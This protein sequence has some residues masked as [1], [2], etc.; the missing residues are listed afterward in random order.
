MQNR[1]LEY[2]NDSPTLFIKFKGNS[3]KVEYITNN[4]TTLLG[5]TLEEVLDSNFSFENIIHRGD[6]KVIKKELEELNTTNEIELSPYRV[7]TKNSN[8]IWIK[9]IRKKFYD[10]KINENH[11]C[12]YISNI[13]K[14]VNLKK[15]LFYTNKIIKTVYDNSV[16]LIALLKPNGTLI[17]ANKTA[18]EFIN[19]D[20]KE[21]INKKFW[22]TNWWD[23]SQKQI[24]KKDLKKASKGF[25]VH[26]E[27]KV[28][29]EYYIELTIKPVYDENRVI[30]LVCEG[31]DIT[32]A[33]KKEKKI[34]HYNEIINKQLIS[35]T[36]KEG[37]IKECSDAFCE[38]T[39]YDKNELVGKKHN[40]LKHPNNNNDE[41]YKDLW[42]TIT[43][44]KTWKG[45]LKNKT[46]DGRAFWVENIITPNCD[47]NGNIESYTA[48]YNNITRNKKIKEKLI[49]DE[50]TGI[51]NR[52]YFNK[53]FKKYY[54][55]FQ[56]YDE[57][58]VL[59]IID[60]DYFKQY[61]DNYGHSKGDEVLKD[62]AQT[63]KLNLRKCDYVFR[64]GGEEFAILVSINKHNVSKIIA[65][66]LKEAIYNLNIIHEFSFY[67][68][69]TISVGVKQINK[70]PLL[71][72]KIEIFNDADK[73]LYK[74]KQNGRN[75]VFTFLDT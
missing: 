43:L 36:N 64:I 4:V 2:F 74:A 22:D 51:Y 8:Y 26:S 35:I 16:H 66:K 25:L 54:K 63:L 71:R 48:I 70:K 53:I 67:K 73:A 14:E 56:K 21:I 30:Y 7:L 39:G 11:I 28:L 13:T 59:M 62:V 50:L 61:N 20:E 38:L 49:T 27:K 72:N 23:E 46:K 69:L 5:Y 58:F 44:N 60:I 9:E 18:L 40:I 19:K 52:R 41:K 34:N 24:I 17:K 10:N 55:R 33:K 68:R 42:E 6:Y 75:R 57:K 47:E 32:Q 31:K 12:S 3:S 45:K 15:N 29:D 37:I 65:N 1:Y